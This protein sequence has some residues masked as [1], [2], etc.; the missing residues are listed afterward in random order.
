MKGGNGGV[1][2]PATPLS[3][4]LVRG[5]GRKKGPHSGPY[6]KRCSVALYGRRWPG[7]SPRTALGP[8]LVRGEGRSAS[9]SAGVAEEV[10][11]ETGA[12]TEAALF[13]E[14]GDPETAIGEILPSDTLW[15]QQDVGGV[16]GTDLKEQRVDLDQIFRSIHDEFKLVVGHGHESADDV[17]V[18]PRSFVGVGET[19]TVAI[20]GSRVPQFRADAGEIAGDVLPHGGGGFNRDVVSSVAES[21]RKFGDFRRDHGFAA[22]DNDVFRG[23]VG[24]AIKDVIECHRLSLRGPGCVGRVAPDAAQV[25]PGRANERAG[26]AGE[27]A[28]AL[29]AVEEFGDVHEHQPVV[30][31]TF[32]SVIFP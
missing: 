16:V 10:D 6:G 25:A 20:P 17:E 32:Q 13:A 7:P 14:I 26:N 24:D 3:P 12:E 11:V 30:E 23:E 4:P 15:H 21:V 19:A 31:P 1:A 2:H 27:F 29:D 9:G 28:L 8:P 5:E 22:G 18:D